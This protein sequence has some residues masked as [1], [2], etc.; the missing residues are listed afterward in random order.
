M[1]SSCYSFSLV[2]II[3]L[4]LGKVIFNITTSEGINIS[5]NEREFPVAQDTKL[6]P[7]VVITST[8]EQ[9]VDFNFNPVQDCSSLTSLL[10]APFLEASLDL[11]TT[12][13]P[14]CPPRFKVQAY[15]K[16]RWVRQSL[17]KANYTVGVT[18]TGQLKL[19]ADRERSFS[20]LVNL[21]EEER[22][23]DILELS[24][25]HELLDF[26]I[27]TLET[28][29]AVCSHSNLELAEKI[30]KCLDS[31]TI[32]RY[33]RVAEEGMKYNL[34]SAYL[35]LFFA[36][37]LR[38]EV[39]T[40]LAMRGEF[41]IPLSECSRSVPLFP[42][43]PPPRQTEYSLNKAPLPGTAMH[44]QELIGHNI[45]SSFS[46]LPFKGEGCDGFS[47]NDFKDQVFE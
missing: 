45:S 47:V 26:H 40:R 35:K 6:F 27:Q 3:D 39:L 32:L 24:E 36:V 5:T 8:S 14:V 16:S 23:M 46:R 1:L 9:F 28:F 20:V 22:A 17:Y 18:S 38:H 43:A 44:N 12:F 42:L 15:L 37:H 33:M 30:S 13:T 10:F 19:S 25:H 11:D 2:C 29:C 41:V 21:P 4:T 31:A 34:K 7:T